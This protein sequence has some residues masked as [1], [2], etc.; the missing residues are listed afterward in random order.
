MG[1]EKHIETGHGGDSSAKSEQGERGVRFDDEME[2]SPGGETEQKQG[3]HAAVTEIAFDILPEYHEEVEHDEGMKARASDEHEEKG[4]V[5]G[6]GG[7]VGEGGVC[8]TEHD[9][10]KE[11]DG[12][13]AVGYP[14]QT[15]EA[16]AIHENR[17]AKDA[18]DPLPP[19]V[20]DGE[21]GV[22]CF[23]GGPDLFDAVQG[24]HLAGLRRQDGRRRWFGRRREGV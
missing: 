20:G 23:C 13:E 5:P 8:G 17:Q 24:F 4:A 11:S 6:I 7:V 12:G 9:P 3:G 14:W 1:M 19:D 21:G 10:E 2:D 22:A 15:G 16:V 18:G